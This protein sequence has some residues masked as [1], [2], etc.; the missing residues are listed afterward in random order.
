MQFRQY[1]ANTFK[2]SLYFKRLSALQR[3]HFEVLTQVFHFK[4]NAYT[5]QH[6][7]DWDN[8][9]HDPIYK[10]LFPRPDMISTEDFDRM[11]AMVSGKADQA[12]IKAMVDNLRLKTSPRIAWLPEGIPRVNGVPVPG[13]YRSFP[14]QLS[15]FTKPMVR[16]CH[17]Y[18][19]YCYRWNTFEDLDSQ[20]PS[21][22]DPTTPVAYLRQHPEIS[23]V[24]FTGADPLVA[25]AATLRRFIAPL[26]DLD[27]IKTINI[28][29]KSLAYWPFRF[30]TDRDADELLQLFE[31]IRSSGRILNIF[32]HFSHPRELQHQAVGK[33]AR[34]IVVA[35]AKLL[36][37]GPLVKGINDD[38]GVWAQM[39]RM[40]VEAGM[41]P[42]LMFVEAN[43]NSQA[44]LRVPFAQALKIFSE[45]KE[46][47]GKSA[48]NV[49]GP[50]FMNDIHRVAI[51]GITERDGKKYFGLKNLQSALGSE[52][53]GKIKLIP[54][55]E[56]ATDLG[57]LYEMF[58]PKPEMTPAI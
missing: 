21:Y 51:D 58:N 19:S 18:C 11:S 39:W 46:I 31:D 1:N 36:T 57:N 32:A 15:L 25:R 3:A 2:R 33:A 16:T 34:R 56:Q 14:D 49:K 47:A 38:S 30:L 24:L 9:P 28:S 53:E 27:S 12:L 42:N 40:Q 22:S 8:I 17:S 54:Y 48:T 44:T 50:V 13:T 7:I 5:L 20:S 55:D 4:V 37:Q 45:A 35:G 43:H 26:L 41:Q 29:S 6:L 10:L 23:Q 52:G